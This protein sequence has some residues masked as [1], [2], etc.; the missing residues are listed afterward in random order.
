MRD[1]YKIFFN[2]KLMF[3]ND[4]VIF[5]IFDDEY[6][7]ILIVSWLDFKLKDLDL[8]GFVYFVYL[9]DSFYDFLMVYKWLWDEYEFEFIYCVNYG[10]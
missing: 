10:F 7:W 9:F 2:V 8:V 3:E 5:F 6:Y 4:V 1:W